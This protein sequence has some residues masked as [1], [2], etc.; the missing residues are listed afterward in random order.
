MTSDV[1]GLIEQNIQDV[2]WIQTTDGA[3]EYVS[4]SVYHLLGYQ[5]FE[6]IGTSIWKMVHPQDIEYLDDAISEVQ[7]G[8]DVGLFTCRVRHRNG[9]YLWFENRCKVIHSDTVRG[10]R[11]LGVARDITD[12]KRMEDR[13]VWAERI[14][15][16]GSW[17]WDVLESALSW[18]DEMYRIFGFDDYVPI[19]VSRFL[20]HVHPSDRSRVIESIQHVNTGDRYSVDFRVIRP[21][22]ELRYVHA[23][24]EIVYE[25]QAI[26]TVFGSLQDI[27]EYKRIEEALRTSKDNLKLAQK[28]AHLGHWDWDIVNDDM[29]WSDEVYRLAGLPPGERAI[30]SLAEFVDVFVHPEDRAYVNQSV[31]AALCGSPYDLEYRALRADGLY[32]LVHVIGET[33]FNSDG[34]AIRLFGTV[35]DI[36]VQ[37]QT[38]ELLRTSEKLSVAGQLAAGIAHEIRNPLTVLKGFV[39]I[40]SCKAQGKDKQYF[41]LM[42]SELSR[43]EAIVSELL[44]LAK[45]QCTTFQR[46]DIR[47]ILDEV[48]TLLGSEATMNCISISALLDS[49]LPLINCEANQ[50]KQVFI[51]II[52]NAIEAMPDGGQISI[53]STIQ[54]GGVCLRFTDEGEGIPPQSL[55][56]IGEPFYTT[57]PDGTGLGVMVSQK[58]ILAHNGT[59]NISSLV[60][61]GTTVTVFLPAV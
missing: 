13:L 58:I 47:V 46:Q 14:A 24:G 6:L 15:H 51:N 22:G 53:S 40:L 60:G 43:I 36:T 3:F 19:S 16:V 20:A 9:R 21:S 2:I 37:R 34:E 41:G 12:R 44:F 48:L 55:A 25:G 11:V 59:M 1:Y 5:P 49:D 8:K 18:S 29:Y 56:K 23:Q 39:Q 32:R 17:E 33:A 26:R 31:T 38:E 7:G 50:L 57:K 45:P 54:N 28:I 4:P 61:Q 52:K 42:K 10:G 35:Q 27:T 30:G